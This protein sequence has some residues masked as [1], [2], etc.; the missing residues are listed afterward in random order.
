MAL[1]Y[2]VDAISYYFII[3][4][5]LDLGIRGLLKFGLQWGSAYRT[6]LVFKWLD[7][8]QNLNGPE[9]KWMA[10]CFYF[11]IQNLNILKIRL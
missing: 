7:T 11:Y 2:K 3:K 9:Y 8:V 10:S 5:R 4:L 6:S 1:Y